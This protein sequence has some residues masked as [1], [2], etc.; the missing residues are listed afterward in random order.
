MKTMIITGAS[1]GVGRALAIHFAKQNWNVAAIARSAERLQE[2]KSVYPGNIDTY[3]CDISKSTEVRKT[4][5][6]I[7]A[8]FPTIDIL[9]NNAGMVTGGNMEEDDLSIIDLG[10]DVNLKGTMYCTGAVVP[11]MKKAGAGLIINIASMAGLPG[12]MQT[13]FINPEKTGYATYG[14]TKA[15]M[16]YF[17]ESIAKQLLPSGVRATCLCPGAIETPLWERQGGYPDKDA[18]IMTVEDMNNLVQFLVD[19]PDNILYKNMTMFPVNEWK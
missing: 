18:I 14:T 8:K 15:G 10:I 13:K 17:T 3:I 9:V 4:F 2:V 11:A 19:Q 16:I 1:S 7:I 6:S 12:G 5:D